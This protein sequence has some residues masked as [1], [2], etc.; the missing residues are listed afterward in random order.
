MS[1]LAD[2]F[3]RFNLEDIKFKL[4]EPLKPVEQLLCVL[5]SKSNYLVSNDVK[6]LMTDDKSPLIH[7]FP[8]E[9]EIDLLYKN[10][11]WQGIPILPDLDIELVKNTLHS[12]YKSIYNIKNNKECEV[13]EF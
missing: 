1:D 10:K 8:Q 11:Y 6:K 3:K 2:N 13:L 4:G 9:F 5:P 12:N 7:L